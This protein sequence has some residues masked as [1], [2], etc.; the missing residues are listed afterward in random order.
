M[1]GCVC[2]GGWV[3]GGGV[4]VCGEKSEVIDGLQK[5]ADG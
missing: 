2:R 1:C 5:N 4:D 3:G